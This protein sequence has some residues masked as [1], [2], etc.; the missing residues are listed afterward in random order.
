[1]ETK[2]GTLAVKNGSF[3]TVPVNIS[4]LMAGS[5]EVEVKALKPFTKTLKGIFQI[6]DEE[7]SIEAVVT[8]SADS[9][10]ALLTV[11]VKN[12]A[13]NIQIQWPDDVIPDTTQEA[14][15][16]IINYTAADDAYRTGTLIVPVQPF[17]SYTYRFFK[18]NISQDYSS[19]SAITANI[20][21]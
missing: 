10:Y 6:Q 21:N 8:D 18:E 19:G 16:K 9:P 1:M 15:E 11:Y 17:S 3:N 2:T 14:F 20:T 4:N 13:G 5:Y 7:Q 12:Y